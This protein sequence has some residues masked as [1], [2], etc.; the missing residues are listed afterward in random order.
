MGI[1]TSNRYFGYDVPDYSA[2][3][4]ANEAYNAAFG[5]AQ[6]LAD[7]QTNDMAL[8]E[9]TIYSDMNEVMSI[10][11]GYQV[12]N[13][14]AFTDIIK[15][16]VE[17]FK[18]LVAKIKGIF[19]AFIAKIG[20]FAKNGKDLV[21]KYEKQ[22]L[23]YSN[24]KKFKIKVRRPKGNATDI[25]SLIDANLLVSDSSNSR[26]LS[27]TTKRYIIKEDGKIDF[28][29]LSGV[30]S[31]FKDNAEETDYEKI[32]HDVD[33]E[34]I[35]E[36]LLALYVKT[37]KKYDY[38][39]FS[40]ELTDEIYEE[41]DEWDGDDDRISSSSFTTE[42]IKGVLMNTKL[43]HDADK[44]AKNLQK[45]ID[46]IIDSLN[47]THDKLIKEIQ[48]KDSSGYVT[49]REMKFGSDSSSGKND[50]NAHYSK[51]EYDFTRSAST[52]DDTKT[53]ADYDA[54]DDVEKAK[55]KKN[56]S[57][58]NYEKTSNAGVKSTLIQKGIQCM[59]K[60]ASNEQEVVTKVTSEY[61]NQIKFAMAQAKK[62]WTSAA[63][64]SSMEHK[65]H[66]VYYEALGECAAEQVYQSFEAIR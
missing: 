25:I 11:E 37:G 56:D 35:K 48:D 29:E 40:T 41:E 26:V 3:I 51:K 1:Y 46:T 61:M 55:Y 20:G 10:Q 28:S 34:E 66:T 53:K 16:I 21:K 15:K 2:Q 59:Q 7:C 63:A 57:T 23:K 43:E 30:N 6:I 47:K 22:I 65:E 31:V 9:S 50:K 58:G 5:C 62:I 54:L 36:G 13:E 38:K 14:N 49:G 4:P 27:S 42:W 33:T 39:D 19:N 17:M 32:L 12:V 8:F 24:W 18:K 52:V 64:Y 60:I 44:C 45:A